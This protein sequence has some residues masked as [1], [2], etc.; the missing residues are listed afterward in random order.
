MPITKTQLVRCP[1]CHSLLIE[2]YANLALVAEWLVQEGYLSSST[3]ISETNTEL[4]EDVEN[5]LATI[6]IYVWHDDPIKTPRGHSGENY[7]GFQD[8]LLE[9]WTEL[10]EARTAQEIEA[11]I[12]E[13]ERTVF[14][15]LVANNDFTKSHIQELRDSTEKILTAVGKTK[16]QY[17]NYDEDGHEYNIGDHQLDWT[18]PILLDKRIYIKASHLEELRHPLVVRSNLWLSLRDRTKDLGGIQADLIPALYWQKGYV[19]LDY[20]SFGQFNVKLEYAYPCPSEDHPY[21]A[22]KV[23]QKEGDPYGEYFYWILAG[24]NARIVKYERGAGQ[25]YFNCYETKNAYSNWQAKIFGTPRQAELEMGNLTVNEY[26]VTPELIDET[27]RYPAERLLIAGSPTTPVPKFKGCGFLEDAV[28]ASQNI[29]M[30]KY[31]HD[32]SSIFVKEITCSQASPATEENF[33]YRYLDT[34]TAVGAYPPD[35]IKTDLEG[36]FFKSSSKGGTNPLGNF[37]LFVPQDW[38]MDE[39]AVRKESKIITVGLLYDDWKYSLT[40]RDEVMAENMYDPTVPTSFDLHFRNNC[41]LAKEDGVEWVAR[42]KNNFSYTVTSQTLLIPLP[43]DT[44]PASVELVLVGETWTRLEDDDPF[45]NYGADDRVYRVESNNIVFGDGAHGHRIDGQTQA[46]IECY[47]DEVVVT[48][49]YAD[50][51]YV[52]AL[53]ASDEGETLYTKINYYNIP[54]SYNEVKDPITYYEINWF[55][56]NRISNEVIIPYERIDAT[57]YPL[58]VPKMLVPPPPA[59]D[60][61]DWDNYLPTVDG[62][63]YVYKGLQ[64][65]RTYTYIP[66]H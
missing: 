2:P 61:R 53:T 23:Y 29:D 3:V 25:Y 51:I 66:Y 27:P 38:N 40:V 26:V 22:S 12:N 42:L 17:F 43:T 55:D 10:Q 56:D 39:L 65:D 30:T 50:G 62:L 9:H 36:D 33:Q 11:G 28:I 63:P 34:Y 49:F 60:A 4:R 32:N 44:I 13:I 8:I 6:G 59:T 46:S 18:D 52:C 54:H 20:Y 24:Y 57:P 15:P 7:I 64:S 48:K 14:T 5:A 16:E 45:T 35:C 1:S 47:S 58:N 19:T 31:T 41:L 21:D 37:S